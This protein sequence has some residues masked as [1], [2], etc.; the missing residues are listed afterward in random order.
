MGLQTLLCGLMSLH[1][2]GGLG[3]LELLG[4]VT[5]APATLLDLSAGR[6]SR[7]RRRIWCCSALTRR[8]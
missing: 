6:L 1:H 2:E 8:G 5:A 7:A 4:A 3:L